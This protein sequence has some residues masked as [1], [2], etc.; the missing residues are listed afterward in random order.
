ME[1]PGLDLTVNE[2][3]WSVY[4]PDDYEYEKFEG[5][6]SLT[7]GEFAE[8]NLNLEDTFTVSNLEKQMIRGEQQIS[9]IT[10][11]TTLTMAS[12]ISATDDYHLVEH[13]CADTSNTA[14][15]SKGSVTL[16]S[17]STYRGPTGL[18]AMC[19]DGNMAGAT[20]C[21]I[22]STTYPQWKAVT[23]HNSAAA[24]TSLRALTLEL[25]YR[26]FF[27]L[28]R[29]GG[30]FSP[31]LASWMNTDMYLELVD[32]LE[33][34]V[35]FKPR[36]LKPG[37]EEFNMMIKGV[38]IPIHLDH[39]CPGYI[40]FLSPKDITFAQGQAPHVAKET[41]SMWREVTDKDTYEA[42]LRWIFQIYTRNRNKHG[43]LKDIAHT[44]SSI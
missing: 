16:G 35:E 38:S 14:E 41:G 13:H 36:S 17:G 39:F 42:V 10:A 34:F 31:D 2:V 29:K 25:F 7:S 33:H 43:I 32:L 40:F 22:S 8:I 3:L 19:D 28:S 44:V 15:K 26:T 20:Y 12:A 11:D 27:K 18:L 30:T 24:A 6:I 23:N 1:L 5:N 37:F 9:A 4:L 21:G